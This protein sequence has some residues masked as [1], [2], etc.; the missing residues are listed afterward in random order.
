LSDKENVILHDVPGYDSPI[1]L[2]KQQTKAKIASV[3][4]ILYAKQFC[5]PDLVDC[6]MEI[7]KISDSNN[8]YI[9]AK[10]KIIVALTNCDLANSSREYHELVQKNKKAWKINDIP[11]ARII[12]VCSL[13][14]SSNDSNEAEI[15]RL[16]LNSL[17]NG[18]SGFKELKEAVNQCILD[19]RYS[20]AKDRCN[21]IQNRIQDFSKKLS[22]AVR[23]D[24]KIDVNTAV[25][26]SLN[27]ADMDLIYNEWWAKQW[28]CIKE[29]FQSF[30]HTEIRPKIDPDAQTHL[31]KQ[32]INFKEIY[33]QTVDDVFSGI[34]ASKKERQEVIYIGCSNNQGLISP[35]EGNSTIRK[36]LALDSINSLGKLTDKLNSFISSNIEKILIWINKRLWYLPEI[37]REMLGDEA[38]TNMMMENSMNTLIQRLGRPAT[39]IF[40][41]YPR[42]RVERIKVYNFF[43]FL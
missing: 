8:P 34:Q 19:L 36:E 37:R 24:Y 28:K 38:I 17:N 22:D 2:H 1:T 30:F 26:D 25:I 21:E 40:L 5:S 13:A 6:E 41:R 42:S 7:L 35:K 18:E 29:D 4:A 10:D 14:E 3:D 43:F 11:D 15:V 23:L 27:D 33:N 20:I 32:D 12:P 31:S 16:R 39:D 9:K